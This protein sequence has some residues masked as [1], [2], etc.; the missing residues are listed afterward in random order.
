MFGYTL[1]FFGIWELFSNSVVVGLWQ[2]LIGL[3]L[4][5]ASK[6]T[7]QQLVT[8]EALKDKTVRSLMTLKLWATAP[9]DTLDHVINDIMLGHNVSFVPV[10]DGERLLGYV[11]TS[12]AHKTARADWLKTRVGDI[13]T[14]SNEANTVTPDTP[15]Q[16]LM[17][18]IGKTGQRK[19]LVHENNQLVGVI[20]LADL[21]A[22]LAISQ[23]LDT[24]R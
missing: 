3:F 4:L 14:A 6:G 5:S 19:F 15:T 12:L 11:D 22:Y 8:K 23:E 9:A 18:K 24:Q 7:Y 16:T 21:T 17:E 1:I 13:Y 20:T 2:L 10:L